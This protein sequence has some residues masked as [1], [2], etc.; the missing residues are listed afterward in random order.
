MPKRVRCDKPTLSPQVAAYQA[1][2]SYPGGIG[3]LAAVHQWNADTLSAEVRPTSGHKL[4]LER[5]CQIFDS[6]PSHQEM[7]A[8]ALAARLGILWAPRL[9]GSADIPDLMSAGTLMSAEVG[10]V[11]RALH[12]VMKG[13]KP[14][15]AA[16]FVALEVE[17]N[18]AIRS[19]LVLVEMARA[20][21]HP[22]ERVKVE[23]SL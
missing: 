20:T 14:L 8:D 23:D 1:A 9:L 12:K 7:M 15:T 18:E 5:W 2:H 19:L 21:L 6:T 17:V 11:A 4:G 22:M 3:V 13:G 16:Q 10:D